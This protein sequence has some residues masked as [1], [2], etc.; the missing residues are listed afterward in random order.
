METW[1][2]SSHSSTSAN[3]VELAVGETVTAVRD[4]KNVDVWLVLPAS[5]VRE[6]LTSVKAI[7]PIR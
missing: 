1:R 5:A 4:S 2:K 6:L 7:H 3:C